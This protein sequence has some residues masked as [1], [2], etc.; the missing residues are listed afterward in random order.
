MTTALHYQ[1]IA[2][3]GAA[4]RRRELSPVEVTQAQLTRI[5][6]LNETLHA[7]VSILTDRALAEARAAEAAFAAGWDDSPLLGV[8]VGLKDLI[9]LAGVVTTAGSTF[10]D[11]VPETSAPLARRLQ[12]AG[13]VILGKHQ[14]YEFAGIGRQGTDRHPA[15][16]NPWDL[17]RFTGGSSSGTGVA[18]AAGLCFAGIGSDTGGSIRMPAAYCGVVGLKATYGLTPVAGS[19]PL[20][21]SLDHLGPLTRSVEDAAFVLQAI[22]GHES[23][24]PLSAREPVC[25]YLVAL[26]R[27]VRG[28]RIAM[29]QDLFFS[30]EADPQTL[31]AV[32]AAASQFADL[33]AEVVEI[34]LPEADEAMDV[35]MRLIRMEAAWFHQSSFAEKGANYPERLRDSIEEGMAMSALDYLNAQRA[36]E[37]IRGAALAA[38]EEAD[39]LLTPSVPVPAPPLEE[40]RGPNAIRRV[41]WSALH[42]L[43][44]L[45]TISLPCGASRDGLP[46]GMSL[47]GRPF[48]DALVLRAAHAYEQTTPWHERH[49]ILSDM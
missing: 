38:F 47:A 15:A 46:I 49:P 19:I 10:F 44:G 9:D 20:A 26:R 28:L 39:L 45:P 17:D 6:A 11:Y 5:E 43:A 37:R 8:P 29:P 34:R 23:T 35:V 30:D 22:A 12:R 18:V 48:D 7:Y 16:R 36:R 41:A 13:A 3:L 14:L 1:T 27:G 40:M 32:W 24:D 33:G 4:Y 2:E 31:A 25:D 42:N 21:W